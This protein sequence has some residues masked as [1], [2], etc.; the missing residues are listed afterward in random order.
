MAIKWGG[1]KMRRR[2]DLLMTLIYTRALA[3]CAINRLCRAMCSQRIFHLVRWYARV[4][5][6]PAVS[7]R[8]KIPTRCVGN[9]PSK[10]D[11]NDSHP[12]CNN[13]Q[14]STFSNMEI[15]WLI[16]LPSGCPAKTNNIGASLRVGSKPARLSANYLTEIP[17]NSIQLILS[18]LHVHG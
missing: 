16:P 13:Y 4:I 9:I 3:K 10:T 11:L 17:S 7:S 15:I 8:S 5:E 12:L 1:Q 18:A 14:L 6:K 2:S